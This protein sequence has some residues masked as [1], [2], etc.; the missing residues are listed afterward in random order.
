MI[1]N[2]YV[3]DMVVTGDD[4]AERQA[5][6]SYLAHEF[7]MEDL[8]PLKYFLNIEV[9]DSKSSIFMSQ[10]KYENKS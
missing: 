1:L 8:G 10:R 7:E 2:V 3:D 6:Q 4:H 9:A 5:L